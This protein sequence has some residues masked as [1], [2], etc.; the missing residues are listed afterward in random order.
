MQASSASRVAHT[1]WPRAPPWERGLTTTTTRGLEGIGAASMAPTRR[2]R[3]DPAPKP[4]RAG[5]FEGPAAV[6][7]PG[8]SRAR[9]RAPANAAGCV[10]APVTAGDGPHRLVVLARRGVQ[11]VE[12]GLGH[13]VAGIGR[14]ALV[15]DQEVL[16]RHGRRRLGL[17][18]VGVGR[19]R[20]GLVGGFADLRHHVVRRRQAAGRVNREASLDHPF[21]PRDLPERRRVGHAR[22]QSVRR[23]AVGNELDTELPDQGFRVQGHA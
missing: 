6:S 5:S 22:L 4:P 14:H 16:D 21:V 19:H 2:A 7:R 1:G 9:D 13:F 8:A 3:I 18:V 20:A 15:A 17:A 11:V 10:A 23:D 12:N